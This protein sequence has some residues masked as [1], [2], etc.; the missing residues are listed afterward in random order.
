MIPLMEKLTE[1]NM[2]A[3]FSNLQNVGEFDECLPVYISSF[4]L[5]SFF[6]FKKKTKLVL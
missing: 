6:F 4:D 1:V 2:E 3:F 5:L